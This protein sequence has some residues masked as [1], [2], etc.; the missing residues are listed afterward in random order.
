[1][2]VTS[3]Y[4]NYIV[5][6]GIE[7][8]I[9][10]L[11][12]VVFRIANETMT[13]I[14]FSEYTLSRRN[15]SF[16]QPLLMVGLGV[17]VPRFVSIYPNRIT[18][19]PSSLVLM[20]IISCVFLLISLSANHTLAHIFFGN[21][22]YASYIL[23][24][25]LQLSGY[26]FHG[27]VYG[28]LRGKKEIYYSNFIQLL[29]IGVIPVIV[30]LNTRDVKSLLY[31]NSILVYIIFFAFTAFIFKKHKIYL[32]KV[33]FKE[34]AII[35]LKYGIPR[36]LGDF[37]LL[38]LL[39]FPTYI[40]LNVQKDL[41]LAGDVAYSI[42]LFNLVG[43]VFGPLCLVLLPEI[44]GFMSEKRT[45]LIQKRFNVF[46]VGSLLL[47]FLGYLFFF[48]FHEFILTILL[49]KNHRKELFEI[50]SIVLIGSFGYVLYI[51]LRSFLDAIHVKAKN[52]VNLLISLGVYVI[53]I[54]CGYFNAV[55]ITTYL[56][57]FAI[58]VTLLGVLTWIKTYITLK[59]MR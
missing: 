11:G 43:A 5:T 8:L 59:E 38:A 31:W 24:I 46:V 56:Y 13:D 25:V 36:V 12:F 41:I 45:D 16:L 50:A 33:A 17:A 27:I 55:S 49:G 29:N 14:G 26:G 9:L 22:S 28:F 23:P 4:K 7:F 37:A 48:M 42:T 10:L 19:L 2:K 21:S 47:T 3:Q 6:F 20:G 34:D 54:V 58:S 53:L 1:M 57:F 35:L 44:A 32:N 30:L 52:A 39:T 51:V 40:V 18:F 15:I